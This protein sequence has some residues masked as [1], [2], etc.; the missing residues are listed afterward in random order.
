MCG[1]D[2]K[3]RMGAKVVTGVGNVST[4]CDGACPRHPRT[5]P[6]RSLLALSPLMRMGFFRPSRLFL[7]LLALSTASIITSAK[8]TSV[9]GPRNLISGDQPPRDN[10]L[11]LPLNGQP[12]SNR[13]DGL[14]VMPRLWSRQQQ[15]T[16]ATNY[17][18]CEGTEFCCP[19]GNACCSGESSRFSAKAFSEE[20]WVVI[21]SDSFY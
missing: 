9:S 1:D 17:S 13:I 21:P 18:V 16:C 5:S 11:L 4:S 19:D 2:A 14:L 6:P 20:M 8:D 3:P 10:A 12:A 15:L 7:T